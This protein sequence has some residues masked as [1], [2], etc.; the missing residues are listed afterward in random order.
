MLYPT[1]ERSTDDLLLAPDSGEG[2]SVLDRDA[3][4]EAAH[5]LRALIM[6]GERYRRSAAS[7]VGLGATE[8]LAISYLAVHGARG[9]SELALDLRLTSSAAGQARWRGVRVLIFRGCGF[10]R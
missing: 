1:Y 5:N 4:V 3:T 9:Q 8:S 6:A 10:R 2:V 7:S